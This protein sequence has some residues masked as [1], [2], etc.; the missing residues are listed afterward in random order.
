MTMNQRISALTQEMERRLGAPQHIVDEVQQQLGIKLPDDYLDF[1]RETNG[2]VG[3]VG[4]SF[5]RIYELEE[6][7]PANQ[8]L[9]SDKFTPGLIVFGSNGGGLAYAY[10]MRAR[11]VN[12]VEID[13]VSIK[14]ADA[15]LRGRSFE[16]FLEKLYASG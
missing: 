2:A 16:D 8:R 14:S 9:E 4:S 7:R 12:I 13:F 3:F 6:I 1:M 11:P 5:L 10:D 15:K